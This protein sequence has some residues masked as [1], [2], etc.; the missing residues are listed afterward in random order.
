[1]LLVN[2][3]DS[4]ICTLELLPDGKVGRKLSSYDPKQGKPMKASSDGHVNHSRNDEEAQAR[5]RPEPRSHVARL[6]C[7]HVAR[8][9]LPFSPPLSPERGRPLPGPRTSPLAWPRTLVPDRLPYLVPDLAGRA[10]G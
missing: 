9:D 10:P 6:G 5:H 2:Y 1:M 7:S 3:W 8:F 4:T